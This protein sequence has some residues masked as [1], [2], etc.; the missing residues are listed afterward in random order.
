MTVGL[1]AINFLAGIIKRRARQCPTS[2]T[3]SEGLIMRLA[4]C[5]RWLIAFCAALISPTILIYGLPVAVGAG[6]DF[7]ALV[8]HVL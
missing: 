4:R 6:V 8:A 5:A 2:S 3:S 7:V 1:K